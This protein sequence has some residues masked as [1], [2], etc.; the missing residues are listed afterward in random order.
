MRHMLRTALLESDLVHG[1]RPSSSRNFSKTVIS[2]SAFWKGSTTLAWREREFIPES[3]AASNELL[4][5]SRLRYGE[6]SRRVKG[7]AA[8]NAQRKISQHCARRLVGP[9][10]NL[11]GKKADQTE[12]NG[13]VWDLNRKTERHSRP[14]RSCT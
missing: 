3:V 10:K 4:S 11:N 2:R 13:K 12:A 8:G 1:R 6:P 9:A 7:H 5:S 14:W